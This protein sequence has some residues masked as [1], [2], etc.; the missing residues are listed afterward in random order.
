MKLSGLQEGGDVT[1]L[2]RKKV[3]SGGRCNTIDKIKSYKWG[4][5]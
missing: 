1:P 2:I 4:E 3:T 5:M